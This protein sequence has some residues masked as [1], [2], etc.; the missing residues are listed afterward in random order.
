MK[1][2]EP[3]SFLSP[4]NVT[5]FKIAGVLL[6]LAMTSRV[7]ASAERDFVQPA[8]FQNMSAVRPTHTGVSPEGT[9]PGGASSIHTGLDTSTPDWAGIWRDTSILAGSQIV[10]AGVIYLMP[11]SVSGW[12]DEQKNNSFNKYAKNVAD[13]VFDNDRL[14]INYLLHP[15]WGAT[16]YI[17]GRERGL[18]KTSS[19]V[20]S[21]L[22]SAMYEFGIECFFE[23]PSIQDLIVTP[24]FGSLLGAFVFE[25]W[26]DSIKQKQELSWYDHAALVFTDPVGVLSLGVE[27]LFGI[28]STV[29]VDY[30]APKLQKLSA[31]SS[32]TEG[33]TRMGVVIKFVY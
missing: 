14:Y 28:K 22:I 27:T 6:F 18:D 3:F 32:Q 21:A 25:P 31:R 20:F 19:F 33:D 23:K 10:A 5:V 4:G 7:H 30:F 11:E 9:F 26:R 29:T 1:L 17:R 12:S 8:S 2:P 15:Y 24:V 16:Y 13:P